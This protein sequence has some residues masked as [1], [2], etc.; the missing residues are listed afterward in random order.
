MNITAKEELLPLTPQMYHILVAFL[1]NNVMSGADIMR[2]VNEDSKKVL[3]ISPGT[4]YPA[5]KR[6]DLMQ[7]VSHPTGDPLIY[8]ITDYGIDLLRIETK[9]LQAA[10]KLA[11]E[12]MQ[13]WAARPDYGPGFLAY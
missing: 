13:A 1:D 9:R 4:V 3:D 11:E 10:T 2:Q 7:M 5:L 12:R 6:L 8:Q